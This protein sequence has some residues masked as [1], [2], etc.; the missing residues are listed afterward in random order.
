MIAEAL[1]LK[2]AKRLLF[3]PG[4]QLGCT[5]PSG[6]H[7][8]SAGN[9]HAPVPQRSAMFM[10]AEVEARARWL[11]QRVPFRALETCHAPLGREVF[12]LA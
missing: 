11:A 4:L 1:C 2:S 12:R 3:A 5:H 8:Y 9:S 10:H 6:V 7:V